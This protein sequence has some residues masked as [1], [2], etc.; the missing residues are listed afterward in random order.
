MA[1]KD[2]V[3]T[4]ERVGADGSREK[5]IIENGQAWGWREWP[6]VRMD[7]YGARALKPEEQ[8]ALVLCQGMAIADHC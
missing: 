1:I 8:Q 7:F 4:Y 2:V 6:G 3:V 5:T